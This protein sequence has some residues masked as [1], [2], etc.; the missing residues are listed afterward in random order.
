MTILDSKY[1][2]V[3]LEEIL[4]GDKFKL[5][6]SF[7]GLKANSIIEVIQKVENRN[8]Y[9]CKIDGELYHMPINETVF[10]NTLFV[11]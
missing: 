5:L 1:L 4:I 2:V 3:G 9:I 6:E 7:A 11:R 10:S 8:S